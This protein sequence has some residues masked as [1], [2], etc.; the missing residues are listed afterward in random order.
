MFQLPKYLFF[1]SCGNAF[2]DP[3]IFIKGDSNKHVVEAAIVAAGLATAEGFSSVEK[4][5]PEVSHEVTPEAGNDS[6]ES[7]TLKLEPQQEREVD[8][9]VAPE[10]E[11]A[12]PDI[13]S[14]LPNDPTPVHL[15][16]E[17]ESSLIEM[18]L[19]AERQDETTSSATTERVPIDVEDQRDPS[20][21][22]TAPDA[23]KEIEAPAKYDL[24][25]TAEES[26]AV[27]TL[28]PETSYTI[29]GTPAHHS[30]PVES[31]K[32][33][34]ENAI[35]QAETIELKATETEHMSSPVEDE[36]DVVDS[37]TN[38]SAPIL[39]ATEQ[40]PEVASEEIFQ[41]QS[42]A[43]LA[44]EDVLDSRENQVE[45]ITSSTKLEGHGTVEN[46]EAKG[47]YV[48]K[49]VDLTSSS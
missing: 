41:P 43:V 24:P 13:H 23:Q 27:L 21:S 26:A 48:A 5:V 40:L 8:D 33:D 7:G 9:T 12:H 3:V 25:S 18:E 30:L 42:S 11:D 28:E 34:D 6:V 39:A 10:A 29:E 14:N 32:S 47:D 16:V 44:T 17:P 15:S 46:I 20:S 38:G 45:D 31:G 35:N 2:A 1:Y 37:K 49:E 36:I 22:E 19:V 4:V